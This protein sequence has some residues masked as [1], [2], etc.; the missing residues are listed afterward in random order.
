MQKQD[1][2]VPPLRVWVELGFLSSGHNS[3][4]VHKVRVGDP[5]PRSYSL[6]TRLR[7][8]LS[9][10]LPAERCMILDNF[11]SAIFQMVENH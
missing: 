10:P 11:S 1:N 6:R 7:F 4:G 2:S 8:W 9:G 5:C 3:G